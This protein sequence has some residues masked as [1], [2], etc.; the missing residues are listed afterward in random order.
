ML[1]SGSGVKPEW[2]IDE[3]QLLIINIFLSVIKFLVFYVFDFFLEGIP[4]CP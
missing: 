4:G 1:S 2:D 3:K